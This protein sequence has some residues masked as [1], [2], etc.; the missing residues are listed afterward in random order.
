MKTN[1]E[2]GYNSSNS[3]ELGKKLA[4][5]EFTWDLASKMNFLRQCWV[6]EEYL[7]MFA[8]VSEDYSD[9]LVKALWEQ[10]SP[11]EVSL[12]NS[13]LDLVAF[14]LDT[15]HSTRTRWDFMKIAANDEQYFQDLWWAAA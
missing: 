2:W 4:S 8:W 7:E 1:R 12:V 5:T 9:R 3:P 6:S 13:N 11:E 10:P 15:F 14:S